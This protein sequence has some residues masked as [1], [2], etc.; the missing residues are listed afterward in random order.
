MRREMKQP[1]T[2][3]SLTSHCRAASV[4]VAVFG[5]FLVALLGTAT[6]MPMVWDEGNTLSRALLIAEGEWTYTVVGEGHPPLSGLLVLAGWSV[7]RDW[8]HPLAAMRLGPIVLFSLGAGAMCYRLARDWSPLAAWAGAAALLLMPRMFAHAHVAASDGP[9][10]A[11][12]LLA[13]A[14]FPTTAARH[15]GPPGAARPGATKSSLPT[16]C[17]SLLPTLG[18]LLWGA[19]LGLCLATKATGWLAPLPFL[20][21]GLID[22]RWTV[23][24]TLLAGMLVALGVFYLVNPPLWSRPVDGLLTFFDLN[25]HRADQPGLNISTWFL[26]QM[27]NL[28][29]PLP[30]YNTLVWL[31][32]T[33]PPVLLIFAIFGMVTVWRQRRLYRGGLL[34]AMNWLLLLV[35]RALPWAP[36]HD[37]I[38]LFLPSFGFLAALAGVGTAAAVAWAARRRLTD[39]GTV[40]GK[41]DENRPA[42]LSDRRRRVARRLA[43]GVATLYLLTAA[44]LFIYAPQWLSYYSP[45]VGGLPGATAMGMEPTY[46]WDSLDR[47]TLDWLNRN[48]PPGEK[49][50]FAAGSVENLLWMRRWRLLDPPAAADLPGPFRW[51]VVQHRPSA[52]RPVDPWLI[53]QAKPAHQN[54]LLGVPLLSVYDYRQWRRAWRKLALAPSRAIRAKQQPPQQPGANQ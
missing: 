7:G 47:Q 48:T 4:A 52:W 35:V 29:Y 2:S 39:R 15:A 51:Y 1:R 5:L 28:D 11:C 32:L 40:S 27:H 41:D 46:W 9:L 53:D 33:T 43:A 17:A 38:R 30:W 23:W 42:P 31:G 21:Y 37:G 22:R 12:W 13:W 20:A 34:L 14:A 6:T 10:T 50:S 36:P 44:E 18:S 54:R 25:L 26:G 19:A 3:C 49:V 8:L 16:A 24:R 45:A